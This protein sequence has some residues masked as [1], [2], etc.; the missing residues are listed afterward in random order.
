LRRLAPALPPILLAAYPLLSLYEQNQSELPLGVIW[1]PLAV[2]V[3][4]TVA[5][6]GAFL[7]VFKLGTKA[8]V[9]ASLVVVAFFYFGSHVW[10]YALWAAGFVALA[11]TKRSLATLLLAIGATATVLTLVTAVKVASYEHSHPSVRITDPRLW[12]T[13]LPRPASPTGTRPDIYVI[14]PDDYARADVLKR[15]FHSDNAAFTSQ[16]KKRGFVISDQVRSPY[17]DSESNIAAALNMDYLS[18]LPAILGKKSQDVR[19]VKKLIE[20]NRASRLLKSLGYRYVHLD[21]DEVTFAAGNPHISPVATPDSFTSLWLKKSVL[22]LVGGRYGFNEAA[23]NERYRKSI[24]SAFSQLAAVVGEPGPKFVVFHTLLPH[25]PYVFG[26][27]GEPVTFPSNSE[28]D[29]GSRV[30]MKYYLKQLRFLETKVLG[31][32]DAIRARSKQPPA[33]VIQ[34]DEGFDA[35]PDTVG[36]RAQLDIRVKG[37]S[38]LSLPGQRG[39]GVPRPANTV[40]TLRFVLNR[41]FGTHYKLLRS[42]SY[43]ELDFPYQFEE[44]RVR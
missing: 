29:L 33:I 28:D 36:E 7:L 8:G 38:A 13:T 12:P 43:P 5:L 40:N 41:Y 34:A 2:A 6:F 19:P 30:G 9:L 16:L 26:P 18:G 44:M 17:S 39:A 11:K 3:A 4:A 20:D 31:A 14:V 24:R 27:H 22:R 1:S 10:L 42:A 32:V 23:A 15:Y 37:L 25:D 21:S 35:N